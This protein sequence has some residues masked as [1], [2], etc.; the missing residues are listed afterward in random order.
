MEE[1]IGEQERT[2]YWGYA[3][4]ITIIYLDMESMENMYLAAARR[5][6]DANSTFGGPALCPLSGRTESGFIKRPRLGAS[7]HGAGA[8]AR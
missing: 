8:S 2:Y 7:Q 3:A 6:E 5:A 1:G 4:V